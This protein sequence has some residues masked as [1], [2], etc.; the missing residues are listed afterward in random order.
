M[1]TGNSANQAFTDRL[2]GSQ[3]L[4]SGSDIFLEESPLT[5]RNGV[6]GG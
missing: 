6:T 5:A 2:P 3:G 4:P 1:T